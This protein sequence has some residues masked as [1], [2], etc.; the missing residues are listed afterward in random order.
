MLTVEVL[1]A[2][3]FTAVRKSTEH[4]RTHPRDL[5]QQQLL[6]IQVPQD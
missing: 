4:V 6:E 1:S 2:D 3:I 5:K